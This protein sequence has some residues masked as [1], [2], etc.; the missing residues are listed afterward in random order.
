MCFEYCNAI[1]AD[2]ITIRL[3]AERMIEEYSP[4]HVCLLQYL[5]VD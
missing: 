4:V 5:V 3:Q 1:I 2:V